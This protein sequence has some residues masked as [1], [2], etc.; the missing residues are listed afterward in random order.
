MQLYKDTKPET[1]ELFYAESASVVNFMMTEFGPVHF[2]QLCRA[3]KDRLRFEEALAKV[4]ISVKNLED[5]NKRWKAF[6]E[7]Q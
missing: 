7:E 6:V 3:L 2:S 1:V 4:Y 5:L